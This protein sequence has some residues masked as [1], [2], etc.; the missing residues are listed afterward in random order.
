[1]GILTSL[2]GLP[3]SGPMK[4]SLWVARKIHEATE[5]KMNDPGEIR[6]ELERLEQALLSG[7]ISE[8]TYDTAETAL[9]A[10]LRDARS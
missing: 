9:L 2:L 8:E 5:Q 6:R 1:M 4:G 3:V 7:E 10:R